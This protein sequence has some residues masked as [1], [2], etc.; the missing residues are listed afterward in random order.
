MTMKYTSL[1]LLMILVTAL[2]TVTAAASDK[3]VQ[4]IELADIT[5]FEEAK[6]VFSKATS[7]LNA[8]DKL[9]AA[10]LQEIHIITYSLEKAVAYFA[11]NMQ[12]EQQA[13]AKK[14][15]EMVEFVH[16]GSENN[17]SAETKTY[18][19]EYFELADVFSSKL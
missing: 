4:H 10:E 2:H 11:E 17:R 1:A 3:P 9:D 19:K 6:Q 16:I 18:L 5:S 12:G 13:T 7:E 15:A 14:M 8:K